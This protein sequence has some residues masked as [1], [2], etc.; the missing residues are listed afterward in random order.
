[1]SKLFYNSEKT[2]TPLFNNWSFSKINYLLFFAGILF[3]I[4]GYIIMSSGET[5]S[6][7]SLSIAPIMLFIGYIILIPASLIYRR[8]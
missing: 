3:I 6:F 4:I 1:M 7:Q 8:G 5:Y 2:V